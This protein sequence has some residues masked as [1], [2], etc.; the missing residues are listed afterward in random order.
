MR[1]VD[2]E[3]ASPWWKMIKNRVDFGEG[4]LQKTWFFSIALTNTLDFQEN[5]QKHIV[6][7][8]P[9][10]SFCPAYELCGYLRI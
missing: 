6:S 1:T 3:I 2:W 8:V 9:K 7:P 10:D 5:K 4:I